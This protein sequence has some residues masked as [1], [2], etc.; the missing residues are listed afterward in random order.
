MAIRFAYAQRD[1]NDDDANDDN[2]DDQENRDAFGLF[3]LCRK[4]FLGNI[5]I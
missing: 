5:A 1:Q 3:R 2:S 4:F